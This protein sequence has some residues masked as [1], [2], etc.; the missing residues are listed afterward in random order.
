MADRGD[1]PVWR[2]V[3]FLAAFLVVGVPMVAIGWNAVNEALAGDVVQSIV[4]VVA[5]LLFGAFLVF[6][7]RRLQALER[8]R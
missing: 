7:G 8:R 5:I 1:V 2:I 6:F 3:L 4:A